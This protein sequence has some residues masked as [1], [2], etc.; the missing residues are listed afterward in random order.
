MFVLSFTA[1]LASS[2]QPADPMAADVADGAATEHIGHD[3]DNHF[4][5]DFDLNSISEMHNEYFVPLTGVDIAFVGIF[6]VFASLIIIAILFTLLSKFMVYLQKRRLSISRGT[7]TNEID[8]EAVSYSGEINAA[9]AMALHMY[10]D[11]ARDE[12]SGILTIHKIERRYSPWS[13]KIYNINRNP[14]K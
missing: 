4:V 10:F 7:E 6:V 2:P 9:I 5:L 3:P 12:E 1:M 14:F 13:S 11:E 8:D